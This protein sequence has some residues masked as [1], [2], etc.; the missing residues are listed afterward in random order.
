MPQEENGIAYFI[1]QTN[2]LCETT[3]SNAKKFHSMGNEFAADHFGRCYSGFNSIRT[4]LHHFN[5]AVQKDDFANIQADI[6]KDIIQEGTPEDQITD[7]IIKFIN[8][9]YTDIRFMFFHS[10]Y[11]QTESTFKAIIR[12]RFSAESKKSQP[13]VVIRRE[14]GIFDNDFID[15][16]LAIRNTYHN[17]G[18]YFPNDSTKKKWSYT[19]NGKVFD[20]E[21]GKAIREVSFDDLYNIVAEI[22]YKCLQLFEQ[23]PSLKDILLPQ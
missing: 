2:I 8:S 3:L 12:N 9:L 15:F 5:N 19:F 11:A 7:I 10:F 18:F 22:L 1:T 14:F 16:V 23:E 20:F 4:I 6:L 21:E 13:F 17:N